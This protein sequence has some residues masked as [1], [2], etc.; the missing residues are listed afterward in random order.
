MHVDRMGEWR[1][2]RLTGGSVPHSGG[3]V[4]TGRH[5]P[6]TVGTVR[7]H[8]YTSGVDQGRGHRPARGGIPHPRP[9]AFTP[10]VTACGDDA[11]AVRAE[12]DGIDVP[13]AVVERREERS[14]SGHIP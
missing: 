4:Q 2:D 10:H 6:A 8:V 3:L 1:G 5:D 9:T 7:H 12:N 11:S 13:A 14:P